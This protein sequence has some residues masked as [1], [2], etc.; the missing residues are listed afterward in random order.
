VYE[1]VDNGT[2]MDGGSPTGADLLVDALHRNGVDVVFGLPGVQLDAAFDSLARR[3]DRV[4]VVHTRHEQATSYM[5]DGYARTSGRLGCCLVVPGP[6]VLNAMSGLSTAYACSSPVLCVAGQVRS[7]MIDSGRGL[8][9]EIPNQLEVLRSVTKWAG[10]AMRPEAIPALV[11][12]AVAHMRSGRP[13]PAAIEVPPDVLEAIADGPPLPSPPP[14]RRSENGRFEEAAA[15][16]QSAERPLI[17]AGGGVLAAGAWEELRELAERLQA[18]VVMTGNAKGAIS[19]RH[20]LAFESLAA[21]RLIPAADVVLA[22]GTRFSTQ[23]GARWR[24]APEQRLVRIDLDPEELVRDVQPHVALEADAKRALG[25]LA[26]LLPGT[27]PASSWSGLDELRTEVRA[28]AASLEPQA[29]Y[30]AALREALPDDAIVI[31]GMT[32][33]GYWSRIGF[34]VYEP[35]TFVTAGYQGTLGFELPT[36]IGAQVAAPA[37]RVV[38]VAGDGGFM[39]NVQELSTAV[40]QGIDVIAVVF[41]DN[42]Y[43]NVRRMQQE[44]FD[45]RTIAS[46]LH[47]PDFPK[48]ADAFGLVGVRAEGPDGLRA[49]LARALDIDGPVLIEVPVG[50]MPDPWRL[51]ARVRAER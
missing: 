15:L 29:A 4:R 48:L 30:G 17:A 51:I 43:G 3:R 23:G 39:F 25:L 14:P 13:R 41:N 28:E 20:L 47:N 9:H 27:A 24:L 37:Q 1:A 22:V 35:R 31:S 42:S 19:A 2:T 44:R 36:G 49:A 26:D 6:G 5:A 8:L 46:D 10:R 21:A 12:E 11:D 33:I 32:Q 50:E 40:Q 16:L 7:D 34:P 18:P 45:G 38:V